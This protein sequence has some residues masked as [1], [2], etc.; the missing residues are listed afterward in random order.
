MRRSRQFRYEAANA[1]RSFGPFY[2]PTWAFLVLVAIFVA[3]IWMTPLPPGMDTPNHLAIVETLS[4]Q[5]AEPEWHSHFEDRR[6]L[7][8]PYGTYYALGLSFM[9]WLSAAEAHRVI[10][11]A[12]AILLPLSF[13]YL[14]YS[15]RPRDH[16][17]PLF[18]FLLIYSDSYFVGFTNYLL[19]LPLLLFSVALSVRL[20]RKPAGG[21]V[22]ALALAGASVLLFLTHP[23]SL[24]LLPILG[25]ILGL[26][27]MASPHRLVWVLVA[28]LPG[29]FLLLR[30]MLS[31]SSPSTGRIT[32]LPLDF[33][34]EYLMRT[35]AIIIS[36]WPLVLE[37]VLAGVL[38]GVAWRP[39]GARFR[40]VSQLK[41]W[42][43][44][45]LIS[46]LGV[47]GFLLFYLLMPFQ[48]GATIWLNLRIAVLAWVLIFLVL[49]DAMV[50]NLLGKAA[51]VGLCV[52]QLTTVVDAHRA[53]GE[54]LN[55]LFEVMEGL[56][57]EARVLPLALTGESE[58]PTPF[59][60][61]DPR[62]RFAARFSYFLHFGSCYHL[63]KAGLS[64]W[65]TFHASLPHVPLGIRSPFIQSNF[66]I[67][68]P[69][70]P[71]QIL[72]RLPDLAPHF[73]YILLRNKQSGI[74]EGMR[75]TYPLIRDV[76]TYEAYSTRRLP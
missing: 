63:E 74:S 7:G 3:P 38:I 4:R 34:L 51:L 56:E 19:A 5:D 39:W 69:F 62:A 47:L 20:V 53:F 70:F 71:E 37:M 6:A 42:A 25:G 68:D 61:G 2:R 73:D 33:N 11:S 55:S 22:I 14:V 58:V 17:S 59:Y 28:W 21:Y 72:T 40:G 27:R 45:P 18:G 30:W 32:Y 41:L 31:Q 54:E 46:M 52:L 49:G 75:Q 64:P 65:M 15:F 10:M 26:P 48:V 29:G 8:S 16:W 67:S 9:P 23:I 35:P 12:Y 44:P 60:K 1:I 24:G 50:R 57:P 66:R 13:A 76:G 36:G 43:S